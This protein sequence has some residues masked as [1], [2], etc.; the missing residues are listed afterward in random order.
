M[1]SAGNRTQTQLW[2]EGM[3]NNSTSGMRVTEELYH[4]DGDFVRTSNNY[5]ASVT[6]E[7]IKEWR[8][9]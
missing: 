4:G 6:R 5:R 1:R 7:V 2:I 9:S 3:L 8:S